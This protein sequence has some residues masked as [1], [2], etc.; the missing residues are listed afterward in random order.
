MKQLEYRLFK[1]T[2]AYTL[3]IGNFGFTGELP[4]FSR[5]GKSLWLDRNHFYAICTWTDEYLTNEKCDGNR[6]RY[7]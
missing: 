3:G 6:S 7:K 2:T 5:D 1:Y 4:F